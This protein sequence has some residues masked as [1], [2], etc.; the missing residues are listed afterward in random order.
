MSNKEFDEIY[1]YDYNQSLERTEINQDETISSDQMNALLDNNENSNEVVSNRDEISTSSRT[2]FDNATTM[3]M[4]QGSVTAENIV[5]I[6]E[7]KAQQNFPLGIIA[8]IAASIVCILI[9]VF[10]TVL[11]KYQISYMA[12]GVGFA[13]GFSIQKVGKGMTPIYGISGAILALLT[14]FIGNF[15]SSIC[16]IANEFGYGYGEVFSSLDFDTSIMIIKETFQFMDV[17]FYGIAIYT[18]YL[19]SIKSST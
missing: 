15:I 3:N 2:M 11:T 12:I 8:G 4:I 1:D 5:D 7:L 14:C 9:W 10:I 19:C 18:G 16:L 17:I 6:E 13:V